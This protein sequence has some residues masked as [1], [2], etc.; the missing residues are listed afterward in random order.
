MLLGKFVNHVR[1]KFYNIGPKTFSYFEEN[2]CDFMIGTEHASLGSTGIS[3]CQ[4]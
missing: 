3:Y 1:K 4:F 2:F